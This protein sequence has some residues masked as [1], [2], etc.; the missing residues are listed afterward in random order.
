MNYNFYILLFL[1]IIINSPVIFLKNDIMKEFSVTEEIIYADLGILL[2]AGSIY[3]FYEN[4]SVKHL[5]RH[6]ESDI[7]Y[8]FILYVTLTTIGL[9]IGNYILK[10]EGKVIRYKTFQRSLSLILMCVI[11]Y[12]IF[13]EKVTKNTCLGIGII[14]FGLYVLDK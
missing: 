13:G 12:F 4:K 3:F 11:G 10:K 8:K 9:L 5:F 14:L 6:F 1:L 7:I 2:I